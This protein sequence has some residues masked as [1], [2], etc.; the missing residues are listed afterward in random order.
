V[1]HPDEMCR[2]RGVVHRDLK[3]ENL[4]LRQSVEWG[5]PCASDNL[6]LIDFGS[7]CFLEPGEARAERYPYAQQ[8]A[9]AHPG[10]LAFLRARVARRVL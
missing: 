2:R 8:S 5:A 1:S 9:R 6:C 4:L 10:L 7:A 3:P